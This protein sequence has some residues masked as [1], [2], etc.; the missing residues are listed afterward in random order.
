M[1]SRRALQSEKSIALVALEQ[2]NVFQTQFKNLRTNNQVQ[3]LLENTSAFAEQNVSKLKECAGQ[4]KTKT[5]QKLRQTTA[6][7]DF[8]ANF[9][10]SKWKRDYM[11]T[12]DL[13]DVELTRRLNQ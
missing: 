11:K 7:E 12:S 8:V 10:E 6:S 4:R 3:K 5:P 1:R 13:V 2:M 9:D